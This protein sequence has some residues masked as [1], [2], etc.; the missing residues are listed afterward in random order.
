MA[1]GGAWSEHRFKTAV[2]TPQITESQKAR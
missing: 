1:I 2:Y